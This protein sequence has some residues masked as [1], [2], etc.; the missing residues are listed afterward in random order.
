MSVRVKLL[1]Q[2]TELVDNL[3]GGEYIRGFAAVD[4]QAG[5]LS[6]ILVHTRERY[7]HNTGLAG[8]LNL[9]IHRSYLVWYEGDYQMNYGL[10]SNT[11]VVV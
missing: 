11:V 3:E 8:S 5:K 6:P 10:S 9:D 7:T 2:F 1:N 4:D